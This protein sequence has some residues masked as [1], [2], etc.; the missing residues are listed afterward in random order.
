[1]WLKKDLIDKQARFW[2]LMAQGSTLV[3]AC[4]TVGVN[5]RTVT[6]LAPSYRRADPAEE[7]TVVG[8]LSVLE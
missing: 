2:V 6:A 1:M 4:D 3:A 8:A 7:A 5:R